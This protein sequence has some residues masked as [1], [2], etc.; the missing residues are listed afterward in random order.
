MQ[1]RQ[2]KHRHSNDSALA[3]ILQCTYA[4]TA[5]LV[6]VFYALRL[7]SIKMGWFSTD[8]A[9]NPATPRF[10]WNPGAPRDR[11]NRP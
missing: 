7:K 9:E 5:W 8:L 10:A 1:H 2:Y 6:A 11:Q 4:E 3:M